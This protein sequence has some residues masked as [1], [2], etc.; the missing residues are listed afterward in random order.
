MV[1]FIL[2]AIGAIFI[3]L[4]IMALRAKEKKPDVWLWVG[5]GDDPFKVHA[6]K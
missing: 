4:G 6:E 5:H 3:A 2:L 1:S